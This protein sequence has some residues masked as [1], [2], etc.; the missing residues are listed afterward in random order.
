M[1]HVLLFNKS[2]VKLLENGRNDSTWKLMHRCSL[3][4]QLQ[5]GKIIRIYTVREWVSHKA[6]RAT[7]ISEERINAH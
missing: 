7:L 2:T 5:K 3:T 1:A 4:I 6:C